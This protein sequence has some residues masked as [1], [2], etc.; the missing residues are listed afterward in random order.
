MA[1][2]INEKELTRYDLFG[3]VTGIIGLIADA[4]TLAALFKVSQDASDTSPQYLKSTTAFLW[5]FSFLCIV[6]TTLIAGFYIRRL[7]TARHRLAS[8]EVQRKRTS[9]IYDGA[10]ALTYTIGMPLFLVYSLVSLLALFDS[11]LRDSKM[12]GTAGF[13]IFILMGFGGLPFSLLVCFFLNQAAN[14]MY[15]GF[16][17]DYDGTGYW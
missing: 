14:R 12:A 6:Y 1:Q 2:S 4:I 7:F 10:S 13:G 11:S 9:I 15:A 17:P 16:D 5:M 8:T 3:I